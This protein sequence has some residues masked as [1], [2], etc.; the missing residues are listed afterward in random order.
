MI[1][2]REAKEGWQDKILSGGQDSSMY[3]K[4][5]KVKIQVLYRYDNGVFEVIHRGSKTG[6]SAFIWEAH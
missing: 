5:G 4:A 6:S 2:N 3:R 1:L